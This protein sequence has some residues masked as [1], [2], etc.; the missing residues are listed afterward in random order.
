M[1]KFEPFINY[2][3]QRLAENFFQNIQRFGL[4]ESIQMIAIIFD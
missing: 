4:F 2:V 1:K 3:L